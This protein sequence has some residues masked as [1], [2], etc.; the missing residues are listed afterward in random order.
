MKSKTTF[1][2]F[3]IASLIIIVVL[4]VAKIYYAAIALIIGWLVI[5]H[6]E[7]WSL[8]RYRKLPPLDE[9]IRD[10]MNK[11]LRNG[12]I[13]FGLVTILTIFTYATVPPGLLR[14]ALELYLA[15]LL[16]FIAIVYMLSYLYYDRIETIISNKETKALRTLLVISGVSFFVFF[17]NTF[18]SGSIY[19]SMAWLTFHIIMLFGSA[20]TFTIGIIGCL[21]IFLKNLFRTP[22][23]LSGK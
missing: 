14:P 1:F 5:N 21:V 19:P 7:I 6:L 4:F 17:F 13:V 9:R 11:A 20:L 2:L 8:I 3:F 16:A 18:Y 15:A 22:H 10:N 12:F 23:Y